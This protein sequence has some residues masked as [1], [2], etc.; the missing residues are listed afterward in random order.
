MSFLRVLPPPQ[1]P[2]RSD[3]PG[4]SFPSAAPPPEILPRRHVPPE[5]HGRPARHSA[6]SSGCPR[7]PVRPDIRR[8][9]PT[10]RG[11][12][13]CRISAP[14][15]MQVVAPTTDRGCSWS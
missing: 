6:G 7:A 14:Y 12:R 4:S 10:A 13:P 2:P 11:S 3:L 15:Q 9:T 1:R 8:Q 5:V